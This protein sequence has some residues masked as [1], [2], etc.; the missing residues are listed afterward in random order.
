[1]CQNALIFPIYIYLQN[2]F[3]H[4]DLDI[5]GVYGVLRQFE[6][7]QIFIIFVLNYFKYFLIHILGHLP[8][9]KLNKKEI[10]NYIK[11]SC[12]IFC[13]KIIRYLK[14]F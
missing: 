7:Y 4:F 3:K 13:V 10:L 12:I 9:K 2:E 8:K 11:S 14:R 5:F 1:M 6:L